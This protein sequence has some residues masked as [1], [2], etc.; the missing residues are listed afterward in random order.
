M[1]SQPRLRQR[2][3]DSGRSSLCR[4]CSAVSVRHVAKNILSCMA[5]MV[6]RH[7]RRKAQ[8]LC[9]AAYTNSMVPASVVAVSA[10]I[11]KRKHGLSCMRQSVPTSFAAALT[12][13]SVRA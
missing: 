3:Q 13:S 8:V 7:G 2:A 11:D 4:A 5:G 10:S 1:L 12:R 6:H 9:A